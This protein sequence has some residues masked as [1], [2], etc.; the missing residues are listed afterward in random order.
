MPVLHS[1]PAR[2]ELSLEH[3]GSDQF[4][5]PGYSVLATWFFCDQPDAGIYQQASGSGG[6]TSLLEDAHRRLKPKRLRLR[7]HAGLTTGTAEFPA[8]ED[9][10]T[11]PQLDDE[12]MPALASRRGDSGRRAAAE[13][14]PVKPRLGFSRCGGIGR[15]AVLR[16]Q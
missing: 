2:L 16:G 11:E 15:H 14:V 1:V 12:N 9:D 10:S 5:F 7:M 4:F 8:L 3:A 13:P 6:P